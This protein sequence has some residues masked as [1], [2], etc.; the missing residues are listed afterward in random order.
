MNAYRQALHIEA[1]ASKARIELA[2]S[3]LRRNEGV[4]VLSQQIALRPEPHRIL[5]EVIEDP[6]ASRRS[7]Q[8]YESLVEAAREF[9]ESSPLGHAVAKR[10][11]EWVVVADTGMG[12][13]QIWHAS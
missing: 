3:L 1:D 13:V 2:S 10:K 11:L 8:E 6:L 5:C 9:L 12:T 7:P 4:V